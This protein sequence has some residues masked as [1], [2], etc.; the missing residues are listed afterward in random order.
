MVQEKKFLSGLLNK[1][2]STVIFDPPT[3]TLL[4]SKSWASDA[5]Q[6]KSMLYDRSKYGLWL[7]NSISIDFDHFQSHLVQC[8]PICT[9]DIWRTLHSPTQSWQQRWAHGNIRSCFSSYIQDIPAH[10]QFYQWSY[11]SS[12]LLQAPYSLLE[13]STRLSK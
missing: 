10:W 6:S 5:L 1:N 8:L 11:T 13:V 12:T 4:H 3:L 2:Q 7:P 9:D